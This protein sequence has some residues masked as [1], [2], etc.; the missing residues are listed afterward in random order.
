[1]SN[2]LVTGGAGYIGNYVVELLLGKGYNVT[3]LDNLTYGY[4]ALERFETN[5][6]FRFV[7]GDICSESDM[8]MALQ[9]VDSVIALA[10]IVGDPAC[11]IN[12][13]TTRR[14]N[15]ESTK[16]LVD[17]A[18]KKDIKRVVFASSCSVYG[19]SKDVS[20]LNEDSDLNPVSLYAETRIKS[21]QYLL[22]HRDQL[23]CVILRLSTVFGV[24]KRMRF[25]LAINTMVAKAIYGKGIEVFG[26]EQWR[27]FV[28]VKDVAKAFVL[29]FESDINLVSGEIFNV[30]ST[31]SNYQIKDVAAVIAEEIPDT[32]VSES[33]SIVDLR[34]YNVT[35]EKIH[36]KMNFKCD[37]SVRDG[38]R[39]LATYVSLMHPDINDP[40]YSNY[41]T[42]KILDQ[43]S[44]FIPYALPDLNQDEKDEL[45]HTLDSNWLSTGPKT[46]KFEDK[47]KEYFDD[48]NLE[49]IPVSSCT[50]ALHLQLLAAGIGPG[51][52]VIT[53]PLT[54][55]ATINS[56]IYTGAT[57]ILVDIDQDTMNIDLSRIEEKITDK[58]KA[59]VP[60][61]YA[62]QAVNHET[63]N[64]IA[65]K[66][67]L[68]ILADAA[69]AMGARYNDKL[70][71]TY[72]DSAAFSFYATKNMTTG[73][74]GLITT[75]NHEFADKI[76]RLLIHGMNKD[77][78]KR[79]SET[80]SWYYEI[81]DLGYKYNFTD[82]QAALGLHQLSKLDQFNSIR[83]SYADLYDNELSSVAG[84]KFHK[85]D[86]LAYCTRHLYP[87]II[88]PQKTGIDRGNLIN[89]LKENRIGTSVHYVPIPYHP[90]YQ[91]Q[92]G[93]APD[94]FP[95]TKSI[96]QGLLS[97]PLYPK[98]R[99]ED[100]VHVAETVK[101]IIGN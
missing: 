97:L 80:G 47:L 33:P 73:E 53:T 35:F 9:N 60:V 100:V 56:I 85:I 52:E 89:L 79:F 78:W 32:Q 48:D 91:K 83:R 75:H 26:G 81:S 95:V 58:T 23:H 6:S 43:Q 64:S 25:D 11:S 37:Y 18:I 61:Y 99:K 93:I 44:R 65:I 21:E 86:P 3:V 2:V 7:K 71:G 8:I 20:M 96:Y 68:L 24:S 50:A 41:L 19:S 67:K 12:E 27:P 84:I 76:R 101:R 15:Y 74:G 4:A 31:D 13:E 40:I 46:K 30:G 16:L 62:G 28:N 54:F 5:N 51:D 17:L 66:H 38:V 59:I 1:M 72:E 63:L 90:F 87:I 36:K 55:C 49:V 29:A 57:P 10:A 34:N 42:W 77:A 69:H 70:C 82:M 14:V 39:E 45:I 88:D 92:L 94:D 98:M 22:K